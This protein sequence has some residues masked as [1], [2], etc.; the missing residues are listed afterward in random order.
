MAAVR[1]RPGQMVDARFELLADIG[2]MPDEQLP[3]H[4]RRVRPRDKEPDEIGAEVAGGV[5]P[6]LGGDRRGAWR[7][8]AGRSA[9][10][11]GQG[12]KQ[13]AK[14]DALEHRAAHAVSAARWKPS[15]RVRQPPSMPVS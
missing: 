7:R 3:R 8:L 13:E 14:W 10:A 15:S 11:A 6:H 1:E 9:S 12:G 4:R 2:L 5:G